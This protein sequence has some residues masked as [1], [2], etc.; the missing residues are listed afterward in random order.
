MLGFIIKRLLYGILV[1][2]G[3]VTVVFYL[4]NILPGDPARLMLGQRADQATIDIINKEL[5]RDK[6]IFVQFVMYVN[7]LSPIS[8]HNTE[9]ENHFLYFDGDK[10]TNFLQLFPVSESNILVLKTPYLRRSY[11]SKRKVLEIITDT[12]PETAILAVSAIIFASFWGILIGVLTAMYKNKWFDKFASFFSILGMSLPSFF[13]GILLAW[14]FG[15]ILRDYTGL[16]HIG[17]LYA[18]DGYGDEYLELKN[19]L[20][21]TITLGIRPLS[22]I[23]QLMRGSMLDELSADYI[24]TA[25]AKGLSDFTVVFKPCINFHFRLV[26]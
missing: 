26:C 8:V 22:V 9:D 1:L 13:A 18:I 12:L 17:S 4:F 6:P 10:Y 21:P 5:G 24:R 7:D 14:F 19:L 25:R 23:I 16:N 11:V 3:V 15:Y 20:L 2:M